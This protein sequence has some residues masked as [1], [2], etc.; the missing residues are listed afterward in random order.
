M[1]NYTE[2]LHYSIEDENYIKDLQELLHEL[3]FKQVSL[4]TPSNANANANE[5]NKLEASISK[6]FNDHETLI[7]ILIEFDKKELHKIT[8]SIEP[9]NKEDMT[10]Y[11]TE[12]KLFFLEEIKGRLFDTINKKKN[13]YTLRNYKLIYNAFPIYGQYKI[14]GDNNILFHTLKIIPKDEP[15]TEHVICFDVEVE[16]RNFERARSLAYN[17]TKEFC[18]FLSVLLDVSFYEPTSKFLNFV[19]PQNTGTLQGYY[20]KRY[21]TAFIDLELQLVVKDNMNGL[22][23]LKEIE[24]KSSLA[25]YVSWSID[26]SSILNEEKIGDSTAIEEVFD[27]HR[28]YKIEQSLK[29]SKEYQLNDYQEEIDTQIHFPNQPIKIPRQIRNYFKGINQYKKQDNKNYLYVRNACRL[30]NKSKIWGIDDP[31]IEISFLV[32]S[33]ETLANTEEENDTKNF[34]KFVM[35]YNPNATKEDLDELYSIRSKLF[36]SGSFSF[37]EYNFDISPYANPLYAEAQRKYVSY[38]SLL[39]ETFI[40]WI[41]KHI[42]NF[43]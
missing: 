19:T 2:E 22:C 37:F 29:I 23:P 42:L 1:Y 31:S 10:K 15:L 24:K 9:K 32:A 20:T 16:E 26:G 17:I 7:H 4:T 18:N 34:T 12:L 41:Q 3:N 38:K 36:H 30:Y 43:Q 27:K 8:L 6:T 5:L 40:N 33:I 21:R 14:N 11:E 39:R 35:K 25:G 13:K 28:I